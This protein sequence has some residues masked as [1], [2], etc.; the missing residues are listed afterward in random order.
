[1]TTLVVDTLE[2][3]ILTFAMSLDSESTD[4]AVIEGAEAKIWVKTWVPELVL[5]K[6]ISPTSSVTS[7]SKT[8]SNL[9]LRLM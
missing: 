3:K 6:V 4:I 7:L 2:T 1:M 9:G 8:I 5:V